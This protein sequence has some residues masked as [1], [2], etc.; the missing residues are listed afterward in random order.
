MVFELAFIVQ[1]GITSIFITY[2]TESLKI[3]LQLVFSQKQ[4]D[5]SVQTSYF[6]LIKLPLVLQN[7]LIEV[8]DNGSF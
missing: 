8:I 1:H 3:E 7:V 2:L 5:G 4:H 6:L